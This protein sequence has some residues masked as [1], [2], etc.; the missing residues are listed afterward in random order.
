MWVSMPSTMRR[1]RLAIGSWATL[2]SP[3]HG[4]RCARFRSCLADNTTTMQ[5][6]LQA[7]KV[8][9]WI[10]PVPGGV[11]PMTVAMLMHATLDAFARTLPK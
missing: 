3:R 8:A 11:G 9:S 10:T 4:H 2:S 6:T 5:Y 1:E 7:R